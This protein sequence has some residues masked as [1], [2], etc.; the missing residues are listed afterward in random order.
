MSHMSPAPKQ[1]VLEQSI[2]SNYTGPEHLFSMESTSLYASTA[3][4]YG[5]QKSYSAYKSTR[6]TTSTK[7]RKLSLN[8]DGTAKL[9]NGKKAIENE[10][11]RNRAKS[12][13]PSVGV[14]L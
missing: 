10:S 11:K 1:S 3:H 14:D 8:K 5:R 6:S 12:T 13:I 2:M 4:N 9:K 7:S